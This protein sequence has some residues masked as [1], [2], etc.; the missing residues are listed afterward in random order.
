MKNVV[1]FDTKP[2]DRKWFDALKD[3]YGISIKYL[4]NRLDKNT[5]LLAYGC[6]A[7]VAFVSDNMDKDTID[8]LKKIGVKA[9]ALRCAGFNNVDLKACG[10][11]IKVYRVP[12]YSPNSVAEHAMAMLLTLNRKTHRAYNR[13]RE[14]NFS[15]KGL[16]G[17]D[18]KGKTAGIAGMGKIGQCLANIC[19][20]FGMKVIAYDLYPVQYNGVEYVSLDELWQR[21]DIISLH[22][23]LT[24]DTYHMMNKDAFAKMKDGVYIINTSRGALVD[25]E[26]LLDAIKAGKVGGAGLDVYEEETQLFYEDFSDQV[27][28]DDMLNLLSSQP[29]VLITSHQAFLT[30]EALKAIA[31]TTLHNLQCFFENRNTENQLKHEQTA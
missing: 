13:T 2:Y 27:L 11:D 8:V 12:A 15:L 4:E 30:E 20:G 23:P 22:C 17:F 25:S 29:N 24:A 31:E 10:D 9:I 19:L 1:F 26:A 6:E 21:S 3:E 28:Q 18:L 5:A 7:V 16:T 14:F